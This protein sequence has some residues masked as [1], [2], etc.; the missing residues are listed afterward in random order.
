MLKANN[1]NRSEY[2]VIP[3]NNYP[4]RFETDQSNQ[5]KTTTRFN[6]FNLFSN[7]S[8]NQN[9]NNPPVKEEQTLET[10]QILKK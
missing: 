2:E 6:F 9:V 7:E 1:K 5:G 4:N 3:G 10:S 8:Q